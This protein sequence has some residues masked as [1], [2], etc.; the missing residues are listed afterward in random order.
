M[1]AALA[2]G[3]S[4]AFNPTEHISRIQGREYLEVKWRIAWFRDV[5]PTGSIVSEIISTSPALV[6][7]TVAIDGVIVAVAHG[8]ADD[9]G[10]RVVWAGK[11]IEKAET[12]AIGRALSHAGFGTQFT[13]DDEQGVVDSPVQRPQAAPQQQRPQ[14]A[15]QQNAGSPIAAWAAWIASNPAEAGKP[16][17]SAI[18]VLYTIALAHLYDNNTHHM[19]NSIAKAE[20]SGVLKPDMTIAQALSALATRN[21]SAA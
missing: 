12:A 6:K 18:G 3:M 5:H 11:A 20:Q 1:A 21:E 19:K 9:E 10:K 4:M 16:F 8:S 14:A 15:P 17:K 7:A 2:K 13:E